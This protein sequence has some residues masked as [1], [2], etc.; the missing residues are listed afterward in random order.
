M[1]HFARIEDGVVVDLIVID[2]NDI[3]GGDFPNS[4]PLGQAFIARLAENEPRLQGTWLQT[5]YN[6]NFR[7]V[8]GQEGMHY[9]ETTDRFIPLHWVLVDGVWTDPDPWV[10]PQ[11]AGE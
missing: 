10:P 7:G 4:E 11:D 6:N 2:N 9:D 5:S 3:E 1:A 8:L